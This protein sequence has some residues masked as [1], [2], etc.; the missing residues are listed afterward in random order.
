MKYPCLM[1]FLFIT[2]LTPPLSGGV[3]SAVMVDAD[4]QGVAL[5]LDGTY[6]G[7]APQDI[8]N[9]TPGEHQVAATVTGHPAQT[10]NITM[11]SG[12][13]DPVH[14]VFG[15]SGKPYVPGKLAVRDCVGEPAMTGLLGTSVTVTALSDGALMAYY[16]GFGDGIRCAGSRDGSLWYEYPDE[17]LAPET[18]VSSSS[19]LS[20]PWVFEQ[21]D[22]GFRMIYGSSDRDGPALYSAVSEDGTRFTP[23][24][25]VTL[26][27]A[28]DSSS[29]PGD[30]FSIPS[31][32]RL[33]DGRLRMYYAAPGG[34]IRSAVSGDDGLTWTGE[35]GVRL[36]GATDPSAVI[37]P[38]GKPGLFYVDLS[39]GSKGQKLMLATSPD[40]LVFTPSSLG[41]L[42]ESQEKGVWILDPDMLITKDGK[43]SLFF[44]L[45]GSPGEA[46]IRSP[47]IMKS[48]IDIPCLLSKISG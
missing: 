21:S 39:A 29:T 34:E 32:L 25:R 12:T 19:L 6:L 36:Q 37:L 33:A 18:G 47:I 2:V 13:A 17:C 31:G 24:G 45:I 28:P 9:I 14:F 23:E 4:L 1:I 7:Q 27:H 35:E 38:G 3:A 11:S 48:V 46:G 16:S 20:S 44:S 22:G 15:S 5:F 42:L 10:K 30:Q 8:Q 43:S 40:G 26:T 41:P